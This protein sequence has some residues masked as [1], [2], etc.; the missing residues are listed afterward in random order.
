MHPSDQ[1]PPTPGRPSLVNSEDAPSASHPRM[2]GGLDCLDGEPAAKWGLARFPW[3]LC[4]ALVLAIGAATMLWS[5]DESGKQIIVAGTDPVLAEPPAV[6]DSS[7][8]QAPD[9]DAAPPILVKDTPPMAESAPALKPVDLKL[10]PSAPTQQ[11]SGRFKPPK[12]PA[13][14]KKIAP[15]KPARKKAPSSRSELMSQA[16]QE[17]ALLAAMVT[18]TKAT[19]A[20]PSQFMLK[21]KQ[22]AA[23]KS[24]AAAKLCR[25]RLCSG[26]EMAAE[27]LGSHQP[28]AGSKP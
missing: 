19:S 27:C 21:W 2:V 22:C 26:N 9:S 25:A 12:K 28:T 20:I 10:A 18:H 7:G 23:A 1:N 5:G 14:K 16:D 4:G 11:R 6:P 15:P 13:L 17:V 3:A 24:V 8:E